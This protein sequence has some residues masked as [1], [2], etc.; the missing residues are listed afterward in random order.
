MSRSQG[1]PSALLARA[2]V[3][4]DAEADAE[5]EGAP[6]LARCMRSPKWLVDEDAD[7]RGEVDAEASEG[8]RVPDRGV[9]GR[10]EEA[11]FAA[12]AAA[13]DEPTAAKEEAAA[14]D[15]GVGEGDGDSDGDSEPVE[16]SRL[17]EAEEG[18]DFRRFDSEDAGDAA[19]AAVAEAEANE[20]D[21][22]EEEEALRAEFG[23]AAAAA[24]GG[25]GA[26]K[27]DDSD[28][29]EDEGDCGGGCG[30]GCC[31]CDEPEGGKEACSAAALADAAVVADSAGDR[32]T[33]VDGDPT[34]P[35]V[36][37]LRTV[38]GDTT[39]ALSHCGEREGDIMRPQP[40]PRDG[41]EGA[42]RLCGVEPRPPPPP[43][44]LGTAGFLAAA[45]RL[46]S[47]EPPGTGDET[48]VRS[49]GLRGQAAP[50]VAAVPPG[51]MAFGWR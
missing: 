4:P 19:V 44:L 25:E 30:C 24:R 31:E 34:T 46:P 37:T 9:R 10:V 17:A 43:P 33:R 36:A 38:A 7:S 16:R 41:D 35:G 39:A 48:S 49:N 12:R 11:R 15:V 28:S 2:E 32:R 14:A 23:A 5:A 40:P 27:C 1:E 22:A 51:P 21:E 45:A 50:A 26:G 8:D 18:E 20:A 3:E 47:G 29:R 13:S 42:V 6:P